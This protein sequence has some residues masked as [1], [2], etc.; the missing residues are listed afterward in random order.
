MDL[1]GNTYYY[2][3]F[4]YTEA[5]NYA[6][7]QVGVEIPSATFTPISRPYVYEMAIVP[8]AVKEKWTLKIMNAKSGYFTI[9]QYDS[10]KTVSRRVSWPPTDQALI[11]A[12]NDR[13]Y[14]NATVVSKAYDN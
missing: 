4:Y 14:Y 13:H 5:A 1:T 8:D 3:E 7:F 12:L 11:N 10:Y 6:Q 2:M 9:S